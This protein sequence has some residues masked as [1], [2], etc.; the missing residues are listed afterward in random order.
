LA[1]IVKRKSSDSGHKIDQ[2]RDFLSAV[3][4]VT[5]NCSLFSLLCLFH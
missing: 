5:R 3:T 1:A 4:L 2:D